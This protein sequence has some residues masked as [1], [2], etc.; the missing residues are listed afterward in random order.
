M[1]DK[2]FICTHVKKGCGYIQIQEENKSDNNVFFH[3]SQVIKPTWILNR[4]F[5]SV[6][7]KGSYVLFD[8]KHNQEK[9][10][11]Q[12][13]SIIVHPK[14]GELIYKW[15]VFEDYSKTI[16]DLY[17]VALKEDWDLFQA[18]NKSFNIL[19]NYFRYTFYRLAIE[20]KILS[21]GR[22]AAFNTGLVDRRYIYIY[23]LFEKNNV[24]ATHD[25]PLPPWKFK[26]FCVEGEGDGKKI[27]S[28]YF[29]PIPEVAQYFQNPADKIYDFLK[30]PSYDWDHIIVDGI[31][32]GRYPMFF[33]EDNSPRSYQFPNIAQMTI[34][35]KLIFLEDFSEMV[36]ND[37]KLYRRFMIALEDAFKMTWNRLKWNW[38]TAI[39]QYYAPR[40]EISFLLPVSLSSGDDKEI[41]DISLVVAKTKVGTYQAHTVLPLAYAYSN[42]RLVC[43]PLSDWLDLNKIKDDTLIQ[44]TA[45]DQDDI[46]S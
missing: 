29:N 7:L 40:D 31:R 5:H 41:V 15:S 19:S 30:E 18:E 46:S 6:N 39:P 13:N 28:Q 37:D 25:D 21:Q 24:G 32:R 16:S 44:E 9:N 8:K 36:K 17:E 11:L 22:Y 33:L 2:G 12:A 20:E 43:R 38:K 27:L 3:M 10:Q 23:A 42:A 1:K 34:S 4:I 45:D 26:S 14:P 35:D